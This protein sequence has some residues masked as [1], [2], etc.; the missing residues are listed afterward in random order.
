M[1]YTI[2][3]L[4]LLQFQPFDMFNCHLL[5]T[6]FLSHI[7]NG[8]NRHVDLTCAKHKKHYKDYDNPTVGR[9]TPQQ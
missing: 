4:S 2:R 6:A 1:V 5:M 8:R 3:F 9:Y 7:V